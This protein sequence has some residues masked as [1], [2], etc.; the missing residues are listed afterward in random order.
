[1]ADFILLHLLDDCA[2]AQIVCGQPLE[3]PVQVAL[4]LPFSLGHESE[5]E[6][7]AKQSCRCADRNRACIPDR[8]QQA[9]ARAKFL[10]P[11][12]APGQVIAFLGGRTPHGFAGRRGTRG[13]DLAVIKTLRGDFAGVI[14]AHETGDVA[15]PGFIG[16]RRGARWTR[17]GARCGRAAKTGPEPR[18]GQFEEAVKGRQAAAGHARHII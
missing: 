1:M 11:V 12:A 14:D 13:Q 4:D 17:G 7:I 16:G 8:V 2:T 15:A 3:V 9:R 10:E 6:A 5:A 18:I